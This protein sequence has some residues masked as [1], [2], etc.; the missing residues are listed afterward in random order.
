LNRTDGYAPI[1]SY[2]LLGDGKSVALVAADG[3]VDWWATPAVDS[4]PLLGALLDPDKGGRFALEPEVPYRVRRRYLPGTNI[5]ETTFITRKGTVT[6]TDSINLGPDGRLPWSELV[7]DVKGDRGRVPMRWTVA[8]GTMF[9]LARPWA[10]HRGTPLLHAGDII[11]ALV[12]DGAGEPCAERGA[13]RGSFTIRAGE[14]ALLALVAANRAPVIV[15]SAAELRSRRK[16]T[17]TVW[18]DWTEM[19]PYDGDDRELVTR[20]VLALRLLTYA[21]TGAMAAAATTSLPERIGGDRNYDYRYGWI[22]DTS[23]VLDAYIQLGLTQE[24]QGTLAWMLSCVA[25]TAPDIHPFYGLSGHIPSTEVSLALRGYR[26]SRPATNGNDA[27]GQPQWGNYGDL[28]ECVWLAVSRAGAELDAATADLLAALANRV[29]DIWT[30]P[31]CGIWELD[32]L[33]RNT[34]SAAGCWVALDRALRLVERGQISGRDADRWRAE[35]AAVREWIDGQCWSPAKHSYTAYAGC[36]DLD[37]SLLLLGRTGFCSGE[38]QRFRDTIAAIRSE[39]CRDAL[40]YRLSGASSYEGAFVSASFWLV[41]ALVRTGDV[42]QAREVW[43]GITSHVSGLGLLAE[44][45]DPDTGTFLGNLPQGLSHLALV[46]AAVQLDRA[47]R[48]ARSPASSDD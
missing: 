20:S 26:D 34:F 8:P 18:T 13:F 4:P 33:R 17:Q 44:E 2:G 5:L 28:L 11:A 21:P 47:T 32:S 16:A 37:A 3:S 25:S 42:A 39:L 36:D 30:K 12:A 35:R 27:E 48:G 1:E 14:A 15:P 6:V 24:V 46:N 10:R 9:G 43:R 38:D 23:F 31:D 41:D 29:C 22:R 40:V 45:I 19:I 7:R